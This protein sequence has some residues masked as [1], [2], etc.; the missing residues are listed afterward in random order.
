[1]NQIKNIISLKLS[2]KRLDY[3][4]HDKIKNIISKNINRFDYVASIFFISGY[5]RPKNDHIFI[6]NLHNSIGK[7]G[8]N[9]KLIIDNINKTPKDLYND[10]LMRDK[11]ECYI[12][13]KYIYCIEDVYIKIEYNIKSESLKIVYYTVMMGDIS[14]PC[15]YTF[16]LPS[17]LSKL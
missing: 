16:L 13:N 3:A 9:N 7:Y 14:R 1:M 11:F 10:M 15:L 8:I 6:T 12:K 5:S 17:K 4:N 2:E